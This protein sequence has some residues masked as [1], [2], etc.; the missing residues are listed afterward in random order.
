MQTLAAILK[1]VSNESDNTVQIL[2]DLMPL[3][4]AEIYEKYHD[5]ISDD[6]ARILFQQAQR[7]KKKN[8]FTDAEIV[9]H[10]NPQ[11]KNIPF[12]Y[13]GQSPER[14]YGND[15]IPDRI[16]E[17][18]EPGM[19]SSMFS[20]AAYLT[21]LYREARELHKKES[22]YHLDK[23]RPDLKSLSLSQEN[24][25]DEISTLE[26]S[27]E[28]LFTALKGDNDKDEQP[29]LKRLSEKHQSITLPYH[30]P[31]QII[32]KISA[33]KKIFPAVNKYP[34][35]INNK[36]NKTWLKSIH[37]NLSPALLDMLKDIYGNINSAEKGKLDELVKKYITD[38]FSC[39][40]YLKDVMDYLRLTNKEFSILSDFFNMKYDVN[41]ANI[42]EY[43]KNVLKLRGVVSLYKT[44][45]L[46]LDTI[47][48][49][50]KSFN[51]NLVDA[52]AINAITNLKVVR[53]N[54]RLCD[55]D[56]AVL[57]G[58]NIVKDKINTDISQ[59]DRIFNSPT[60]G[61][62]ELTADNQEL[63]L[64]KGDYKDDSH[65]KFIINCLKRAFGVNESLLAELCKFIYGK[66]EKVKCNI[67]F[68][69][70]CYRTILIARVNYISVNELIMLF[71]LIPDVFNSTIENSKSS[72]DIYDLLYNVNYYIAWFNE[73]KLSISMCYFLLCSSDEVVIS[74][75]VDN[76]ISEIRNGLN[77]KDFLDEL[78]RPNK[79]IIKLSPV[80]SS[81]LNI[82]SVSM[83]ESVLYWM[84]SE[85]SANSTNIN[86]LFNH[87]FH[88]EENEKL[89]KN[90]MKP[91]F[92]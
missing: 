51:C 5:V 34:Y 80:L 13:T 42:T 46:P 72:D 66:D 79:I 81:V 24:L 92:L 58:G 19:V 65:E 77:E 17:Y 54:Y 9:T 67:D 64:S 16:S 61:G 41:S 78:V 71:R 27:N 90:I 59:F 76:I 2:C 43:K 70:L 40:Y 62:K 36:T 85:L 6:E 89:E 21:E 28:V 14:R 47:V 87:I 49:V 20:P 1:K 45:G 18:A 60:L 55:E 26:F 52:Q 3:S 29:V 39:L 44:S 37:C 88:T 4:Y 83:M 82:S 56:I 30:E 53:D 15:F 74:Q 73:N 50:L 8:R 33:L 32:K 63:D 38:D 57:L 12:L 84:N 31:F 7:Q 48:F 69:S 75:N 68:L 35:I 11:I 23:R 91:L 10:N 25:N 22:K 86:L